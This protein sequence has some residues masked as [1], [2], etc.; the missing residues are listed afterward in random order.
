[1]KVVIISDTH[2]R[3]DE[4]GVLSGDVL[5]HCGDV[6]LGYD[7]GDS[8]INAID[9]WFQ[10]QEFSAIICIGG[11]HDR[12]LQRRAALELRALE[13]AIY[14]ED[15]AFEYGGFK[16]YG[17]PWVPDL[18]GWAYFLDDASLA[19]KWAQIPADT[20]IL[21]THTPPYKILDKPRYSGPAGCLRLRERVE[22]IR[23]RVH[24]FGH[25]H[26]S[27]GRTEQKDILFFNASIDSRGGLNAPFTL[28]VT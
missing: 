17:A 2:G 28:E 13:N 18:H 19:E 23:P 12:P 20:D 14:L 25:I 1:M 6:C 24:C 16:F 27:Y 15:E 3:H 26:E 4:L 8:Q 7:P 22:V 9:S 10:R 11:N 5:I 21:I